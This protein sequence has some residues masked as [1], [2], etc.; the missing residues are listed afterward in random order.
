MNCKL[1]QDRDKWRDSHGGELCTFR[2]IMMNLASCFA[3]HFM[4]WLTYGL[5]LEN[6]FIILVLQLCSTYVA[7][8]PRLLEKRQFFFQSL[9]L[10]HLPAIFMKERK[11]IVTR[12]LK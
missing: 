12:K 10:R 4:I 2:L 6:Q 3:F 7:F 5:F 8:G 9:L 11:K 1:A